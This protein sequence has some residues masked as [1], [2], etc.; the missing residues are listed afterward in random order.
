MPASSVANKQLKEAVTEAF[1]T[2][3][4]ATIES[5]SLGDEIEAS[6]L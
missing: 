1:R 3:V 4:Y 5:V 6:D 2:S